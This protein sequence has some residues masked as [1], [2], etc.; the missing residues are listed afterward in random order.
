MAGEGNLSCP[1]AASVCQPGAQTPAFHTFRG[2]R[3]Q[4][5]EQLGRSLLIAEV[6]PGL[7]RAIVAFWGVSCAVELVRLRRQLGAGWRCALLKGFFCLLNLLY[8][9]SLF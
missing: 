1:F 9:K 5:A 3:D 8:L 4:P 6:Q 2:A 7:R